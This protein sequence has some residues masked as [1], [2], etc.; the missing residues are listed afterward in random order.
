MDSRPDRTQA[1]RIGTLGGNRLHEIADLLGLPVDKFAAPLEPHRLHADADGQCWLLMR[2]AAGTPIVRYVGG[3]AAGGQVTDARVAAFL[4][5]D[6]GSPQHRALV[7]L[8]D[9]VLGAYLAG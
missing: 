4:T 9:S 5:R 3:P 1:H 6:P 2:D 7:A 8:I